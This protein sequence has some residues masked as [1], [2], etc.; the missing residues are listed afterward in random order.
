MKNKNTSIMDI[1]T[2]KTEIDELLKRIVETLDEIKHK[3][4]FFSF[5]FDDRDNSSICD[6]AESISD[7]EIKEVVD[8]IRDRANNII[9]TKH[10]WKKSNQSLT[11]LISGGPYLAAVLLAVF[12]R[13]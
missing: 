1:P 3:V 6:I 11:K 7:E 4:E 10:A 13:K 2:I 8:Y 12:D 9:A 5:V